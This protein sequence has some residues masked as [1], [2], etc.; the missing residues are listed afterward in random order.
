MSVRVLYSF[1]HKIGETRICNTAWQLVN[2][3]A[4]AGTEILVCPGVLFRPFTSNV[5]VSPT[6]AFGRYR[7]PYKL[8]GSLRAFALHDYIVSRRLEKWAGHVDVVHAWPLGALRTLK[9]ARR[10]GIP[11]VL[12]RPNAHTRFAYEIVQKECER[13]GLKMPPDHE[14]AYNAQRLAIEE[15]EYR[16]ADQILC[17]SDFVKRT[18]LDAGF[19]D[20]KLTRHQYGFDE[21]IYRSHARKARAGDGLKMLFVG[22]VAPRKGLH[23]A[24]E[25]WLKS[26]A[27]HNGTFG[28]AGAFIPGYAE[29]LAPLL[30]HSSIRVLGHRSDVAE[31]MGDSDVLILPSIEE[32]SAL[33]TSEAR[34]SGCVLV[35]S[36]AAGAICEH[37]KNGLV[38]SVGDVETIS[39]HITLLDENRE[40]L[41]RLRAESLRTAH[42]ITWAAAGARLARV[43]EEV[44]AA[45]RR[46]NVA[47]AELV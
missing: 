14:H 9:T 42:E 21:K 12:E 35:V 40:L 4:A 10:L 33:V 5:V 6:L 11:S 37:M 13:L 41:R 39:R 24:L 31:L 30:A 43:Y 18:F 22:G 20:E 25:S 38:H 16:L 26:S 47:I 2:G 36:E 28:I 3:A 23:Y 44:V 32:G 7:I 46:S 8:L 17:P 15:E 1:P 29:K 19:A 34:G 27:H 45:K